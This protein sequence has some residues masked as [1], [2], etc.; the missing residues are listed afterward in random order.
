MARLATL[1]ERE[2]LPLA[3]ACIALCLAEA[4]LNGIVAQLAAGQIELGIDTPENI[5]RQANRAVA[6]ARHA[7]DEARFAALEV[8]HLNGRP[9]C[10]NDVDDMGDALLHAIDLIETRTRFLADP[11]HEHRLTTADLGVGRCGRV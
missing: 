11:N 6:D 8:D 7:M 2:R 4:N 3:R 9:L 10:T 1:V 5:V